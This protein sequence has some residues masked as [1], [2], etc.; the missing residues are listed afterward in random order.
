MVKTDFTDFGNLEHDYGDDLSCRPL[1][2]DGSLL[3]DDGQVCAHL[4]PPPNLFQ[5]L[6]QIS[7]YNWDETKEPFHSS[8]DNWCVCY[9]GLAHV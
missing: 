2:M 1:T 7:G 8:Y 3:M 4:N 5:R 9:R 6:S